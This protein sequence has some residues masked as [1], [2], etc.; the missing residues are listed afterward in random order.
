MAGAKRALWEAIAVLKGQKDRPVI[1][2]S[3]MDK[4]PGKDAPPDGKGC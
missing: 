4:E 3:R 2:P 1:K